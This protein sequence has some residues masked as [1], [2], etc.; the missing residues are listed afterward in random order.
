L[1]AIGAGLLS[2][3]RRPDRNGDTSDPLLRANSK[4]HANALGPSHTL[5]ARLETFCTDDFENPDSGWVTW[6]DTGSGVG[7]GEGVFR[8]WLDEV[9]SDFWSTSGNDFDDMRVSASTFKAR[10]PD[11]NDFGVICRFQDDDNFYA[12]LI[13]SDG[14]AGILKMEGGER[15]ML[16]QEGMVSTDAHRQGASINESGRVHG[17]PS[18]PA[19]ERRVGRRRP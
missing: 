12:F 5:W 7:Y 6:E 2:H 4:P 16:E 8:I 1:V 18:G 11:D 10:G 19:R 3:R 13:S 17:R 14:Y 9:K 15:T